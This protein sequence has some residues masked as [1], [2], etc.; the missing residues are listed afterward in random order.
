[1]KSVFSAKVFPVPDALRGTM[2]T[3]SRRAFRLACRLYA[4]EETK[5]LRT[6]PTSSLEITTQD[7]KIMLENAEEKAKKLI[8]MA[9]TVTSVSIFGLVGIFLSI[10]QLLG[11][12]QMSQT[13]GLVFGGVGVGVITAGV[14]SCYI[15]EMHLKAREILRSAH[16]KD[17]QEKA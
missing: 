12:V 4:E 14:L 15:T 1:M 10:L 9:R 3:G 2:P 13:L 11:R 6:K 16:S 17:Q 5:I 7:K 8:D